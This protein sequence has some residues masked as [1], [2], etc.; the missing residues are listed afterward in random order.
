MTGFQ[1]ETPYGLIEIMA[2]DE[3]QAKQKLFSWLKE[4][5]R[6][7]DAIRVSYSRHGVRRCSGGGT[8]SKEGEVRH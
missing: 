5:A 3:R 8:G 1:F 2:S 7:T 4:M 6:I